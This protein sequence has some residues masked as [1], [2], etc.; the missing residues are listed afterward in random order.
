M[1]EKTLIRIDRVSDNLLSNLANRGVTL[2]ARSL[3][4]DPLSREALVEFLGLPWRLVFS[5]TYDPDVVKA[6]ETAASFSDPMTRKRGFVQII[7]SDPS[8]IELPQRCLPFY[9][10]NGRQVGE[11]PSDFGSRL[12]RLTMLEALRRSEAREL[13][14]ISGDEDPVPPEL[15]DLWSFR[16][17]TVSH[18]RFECA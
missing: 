1:I 6:L 4:K 8:R 9:L 14:V 12:R 13:L 17:S 11:A 10:L 5:E 15:K 3:P 7:D 16:V 18:L 2:W